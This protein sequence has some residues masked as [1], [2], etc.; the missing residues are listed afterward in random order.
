MTTGIGGVRPPPAPLPQ[1][2]NAQLSLA[3][4]APWI[5]QYS[6]QHGVSAELVAAVIEQ[7]SSYV[8]HAVHRDGTGHGLIALDDNGLLPDFEGGRPRPVDLGE[9]PAG[10]PV[11]GSLDYE[12][13]S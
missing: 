12:K 2:R 1:A 3:E 6:E 8:N 9:R 13:I 10:A 11:A 7:E 5:E 4:L